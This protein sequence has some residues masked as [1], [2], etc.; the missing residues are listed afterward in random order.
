MT[1]PRES[2]TLTV[3]TMSHSAAIL[4]EAFGNYLDWHVYRHEAQLDLPMPAVARGT[5]RQERGGSGG[6]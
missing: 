5:Q 6:S 2:W 4:A 1:P 3:M